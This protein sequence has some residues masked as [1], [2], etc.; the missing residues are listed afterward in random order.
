VIIVAMTM[1]LVSTST[2]MIRG[3]LRLERV[4]REMLTRELDQAREI[5]LMWLPKSADQQDK[6]KN[7]PIDIAAVNRPASHVS[8]DFY[9]WFEL[10]DGRICIVIGDVTGHGLPAA[11]LMATTQLLVR[12]II[13]RVPDPGACVR[14]TNRLL[15][16]HVFSGQFVTLL[17]A[18]LDPPKNTLALAT[19]GHPAPVIGA[20]EEFTALNIEPQLVLAI[21]GNVDYRTQHFDLPDGASILLYTDGVTDVQ[22]PGD[23]RMGEDW[24]TRGVYGMFNRAQDLVDAVL[25]GI[26]TYRNGREPAD[27]L[28]LVAIQLQK[29]PVAAEAKPKEAALTPAPSRIE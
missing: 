10:S 25:D 13:E 5:Q 12:A 2:T 29:D 15:C 27:D 18:I 23:E 20:G 7:F 1:I 16:Q 22:N 11:F 17:V 28:T 19:A 6:T 24:L 4:Q 9:N 14:E 3:R 8:G 26:D 21:D